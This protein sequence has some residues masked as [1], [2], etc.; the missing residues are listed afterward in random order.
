[1]KQNE[2]DVEDNILLLIKNTANKE[3]DQVCLYR[4]LYS[5]EYQLLL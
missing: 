1:M 3:H 5:T 2:C 4:G